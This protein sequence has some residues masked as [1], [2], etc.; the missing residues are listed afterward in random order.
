MRNMSKLKEDRIKSIVNSALKGT[1]IGSYLGEEVGGFN[2][3]GIMLKDM[4]NYVCS[5]KLKLIEAGDAQSLVNHLQNKQAQDSMFYYS[6]QLD[7]ESHLTNVF[8]R[9]G[10]SKVD[11]N[12]FG[13]VVIFDTIYCINK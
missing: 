5:E 12:C 2:K 11:Y 4:H 13:D 1:N 8:W 7:Q 6:V 9:D 3:H 10:K